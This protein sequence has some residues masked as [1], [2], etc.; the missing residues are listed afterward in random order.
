M[1][2]EVG[3]V[4]VV[5][6]IKQRRRIL[7]PQCFRNIV[8]CS[9]RITS[10]REGGVE[11]GGRV[12]QFLS[13]SNVLVLKQRTNHTQ[14]DLQMLVKGILR[15]VELGKIVARTIVAYNGLMIHDAYGCTVVGYFRT[16][17]KSD[18][19]IVDIARTNRDLGEIGVIAF[20]NI[21]NAHLCCCLAETCGIK[22]VEVLV[23]TFK[24]DIAII[25]YVELSLTAA[26]GAY[27]NNTGSSAATILRCLGSIFQNGE[28]LNIQ[29][30]DT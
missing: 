26:F 1:E 10:F 27:H 6:D 16:A 8:V 13:L 21:A 5:L 28:T 17:A 29:G 4:F 20:V 15:Q 25:S 11:G 22:H 30:I 14:T 19:M 7:N 24:T 23:D 9:H 18:M 2:I 3:I 12:G